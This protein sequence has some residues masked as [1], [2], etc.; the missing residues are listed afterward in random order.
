MPPV[1][2]REFLIICLAALAFAAAGSLIDI[3]SDGTTISAA[4]KKGFPTFL[5]GFF[6]FSFVRAM[7]S[8]Y[9]KKKKG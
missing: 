2:I 1:N 9:L 4:A 3:F 6:I 8:F 7:A 5:I